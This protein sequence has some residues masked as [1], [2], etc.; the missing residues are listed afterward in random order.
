MGLSIVYVCFN[1]KISAISPCNPLEYWSGGVMLAGSQTRRCAYVL[2]C[3]RRLGGLHGLHGLHGPIRPIRP[4][5]D[6]R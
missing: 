6:H 4:I 2:M 5:T 3:L 1:G